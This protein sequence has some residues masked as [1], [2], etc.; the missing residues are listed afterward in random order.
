MGIIGYLLFTF[1]WLC[2]STAVIFAVISMH[3]IIDI[4]RTFV[5]SFIGE[6]EAIP[7]YTNYSQR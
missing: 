3:R 5:L 2:S 6:L 7:A 4:L 1:G